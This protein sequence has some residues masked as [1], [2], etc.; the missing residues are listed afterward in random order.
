MVHKH[1][2]V[3]ATL[4]ALS[5]ALFA[6]SAGAAAPLPV[7]TLVVGAAPASAGFALEGTVQARQQATLAALASGRV[8]ALAVKAGDRVK[9]G[10]VLVRIDDRELQAGLAGSEAG[11]AQARAA[12]AQAEQHLGRTRELRTQGF[13]SAAALDTATAQQ[14]AAAAALRQAEAGRAQAGVARTHASVTAPFDG[15]VLAT[16]VEAGDLATAGRPLLTVFA[17]GRL[18]AVVALPA[19]RSAQARAATQVQVLLPDGRR[20]APEQRTE[21]P[22]LDP[23]SQTVEW[24]L[25]LPAATAAGLLP[26]QPV[27]VL[28]D[29]APVA[30]S[31]AAAAAPT[32]PV[33]AV[34]QRGELTA[35]Y[36]ESQGRFVLRAVRTGAVVGDRVPVL[37]GLKGG[38]RIAADAVR[39][40]LAGAVPAK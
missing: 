40:G 6:A 17:P 36:A 5:S 35:V 8:L 23:V 26:G 38:E 24:R 19:S 27:Q 25:D 4:W 20:I 11:V 37:A 30:A 28:F 7:P 21:L 39:A 22:V 2:P 31:S 15:V 29:G 32:V 9:A 1:I 3:A 14:Q 18:R 33:A 34:L 13:V 10:Q 16:H 12:L